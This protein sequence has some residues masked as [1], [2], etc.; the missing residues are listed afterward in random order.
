MLDILGYAT[1]IYGPFLLIIYTLLK[2]KRQK[3]P[4]ERK[5]QPSK[6]RKDNYEMT[7]SGKAYGNKGHLQNWVKWVVRF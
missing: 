2:S 4:K 7:C 3:G 1:V 6:E 5:L